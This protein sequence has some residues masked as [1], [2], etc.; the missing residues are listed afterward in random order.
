VLSPKH[1]KAPP[2]IALWIVLNVLLN[3]A[4]WALSAF[5]ELN[6]RGYAAVFVLAGV[7][8][9]AFW[10]T[11]I[12]KAFRPFI[13]H[14]P[15]RR[16]KRAYPLA[17]LILAVAAIAG[18]FIYSP[19]NYDALAYR[20]PR[21]FH[22][23]TE[24]RWH[25][26]HTAFSRVNTRACG[27]EWVATPIILLTKS[28]RWIFL[29][30]VVSFCFLPG[31]V[32]SALRRLGI[33][34]RVAWCWMW[35]FPTGYCFLL[36]AGSIGNDLGG[37]LFALAAM[38]FALRAR[39]GKSYRDLAIALFSTA[40]LLAGK[41]SNLPL[42]LPLLAAMFPSLRLLIGHPLRSLVIL[43][44]VALSSSIP[45][46]LLNSKYCGDWTGLKPEYPQ[47]HDNDPLLYVPTN[48]V[49][50]TIQNL[51]PPILPFSRV[52]NDNI[53]G[54]VPASIG[55]RLDKDFE[56][57][58]AHFSLPELQIEESTG[59]GFGL[60]WLLIVGLGACLF[61]HRAQ[62]LNLGWYQWTCLVTPWFALLAFMSKSGLAAASR[63]IIPYYGLLIPLLLV[64]V[65]QSL[66]VRKR[67][68]RI[69]AVLSFC[70]AA[71]PLI[72]SPSRP[73]LPMKT[74]LSKLSAENSHWHSV[75]HA[76]R[77]YSVYSERSNGFEPV[78]QKLPP[79]IKRLGLITFDD[80]EASLWLP[81]GSLV[82]EHVTPDDSADELRSRGIEY[83]L[84]SADKV[85]YI[86][87]Q[88]AAAWAAG[89]DAEI[90]QTFPLTL[91]ARRGQ[92]DWFLAKLK[93]K[94]P[95]PP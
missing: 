88:T 42:C 14:V 87:G 34:S 74:L 21:I 82:V 18:G 26:I 13:F 55:R 3:C 72:L 4:G 56:R 32:F 78:S 81:F 8:L 89:H 69:L 20:I 37:A 39:E 75:A 6:A 45:I 17:F 7:A 1:T 15:R 60:S 84:M 59:L 93:P 62:W 66:L 92:V 91:R 65:G 80:P 50:L 12:K 36:Q 40:L 25:W 44:V 16:F 57:G 90:V 94:S 48:A 23:L 83:V 19:S 86:F 41:T 79:G 68:W 46:C 47:F 31:L 54:F 71:I 85:Q 2:G 9:S 5:H 10:K 43:L 51:A 61:M 70:F 38:D 52:W 24:G 49:L 27:F 11:R 30:N 67:W 29:I 64:Q 58:A 95:N 53:R 63:L 28:Y 22:W 73:L 76:V 77:A 33:R 35:L